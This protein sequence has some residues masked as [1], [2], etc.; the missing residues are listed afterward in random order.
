LFLNHI[1]LLSI[2]V[3]YEGG[4]PAAPEHHGYMGQ[5]YLNDPMANMA[6]QYGQTLAHQGQDYVHKNVRKS[7]NFQPSN[8]I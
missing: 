3:G 1:D 8:F 7:Y 6:M 5:N 2:I 4:Y